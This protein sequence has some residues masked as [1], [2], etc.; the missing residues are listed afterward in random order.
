MYREA[1]MKIAVSSIDKDI[2]SKVEPRF[3]RA[4]Y[5]MVFD[6]VTENWSSIENSVQMDSPHGA[7]I[8]TA[9]LIAREGISAVIT[10]HCGPNAWRVLSAANVDLYLVASRTVKEAVEEMRDGKL[11]PSDGADV[12]GHW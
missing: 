11:K 8:Q 12:Q 9:Q 2:S 1:K 7:G 4:K 10:G 5:F 3:G 6:D